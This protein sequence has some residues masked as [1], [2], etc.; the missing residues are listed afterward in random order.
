MTQLLRILR[1]TPRLAAFCILALTAGV[2]ATLLTAPLAPVAHAVTPP[3]PNWSSLTPQQQEA[4]KPLIGEWGKIDHYRRKKWLG[5]A[6]KFAAMKPEQQKRLH[7]RMGDWA[8]MTPEQRRAARENYAQSKALPA[9]QKKAEWQQY[10]KLPD[11]HKRQLAAAAEAKKPVKQK[12]QR[13]AT[14]AQA[15]DVRQAGT[16]PKSGA[17]RVA[18]PGG[19]VPANT[20]AAPASQVPVAGDSAATLAAPAVLAAPSTLAAPTSP[21]A[22]AAQV[23]PAA[24][25]S[26]PA[27]AA[28]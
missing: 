8:R 12:E 6:E 17:T 2:F 3:Q 26:A 20:A 16:E 4:L 11:A 9:E 28:N 15:K 21:A 14:A 5:I 27:S 10:Q 7:A 22:Q 19:S 13:R 18:T 24:P 1:L 23:T 25:V